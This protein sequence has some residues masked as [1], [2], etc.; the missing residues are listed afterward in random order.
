MTVITHLKPTE[1]SQSRFGVPCPIEKVHTPVCKRVCTLQP[2]TCVHLWIGRLCCSTTAKL[3]LVEPE[4][5]KHY[6]T[7]HPLAI[8]FVKKPNN[9]VLEEDDGDVF[10]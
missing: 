4:E 2:N 5:S 6:N 7:D 9:A 3:I 1:T 10:G 8:Y